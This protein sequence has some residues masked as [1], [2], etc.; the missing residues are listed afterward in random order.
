MKGSLVKRAEE[1]M[2]VDGSKITE[3]FKGSGFATVAPID[4]LIERH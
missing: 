4:D 1:V 3:V 2:A